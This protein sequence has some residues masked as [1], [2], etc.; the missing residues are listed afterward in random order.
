M[1]LLVPIDCPWAR[2]KLLRTASHEWRGERDLAHIGICPAL[3]S[4]RIDGEV[5][6]GVSELPS[7][8]LACTTKSNTPCGWEHHLT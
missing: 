3:M 4:S 5:L 7:D 2:S 6:R 1:L 8:P